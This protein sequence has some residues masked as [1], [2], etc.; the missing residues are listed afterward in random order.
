MYIFVNKL[1]CGCG[2][3]GT[4]HIMFKHQVSPAVAAASVGGGGLLLL[5]LLLL[6]FLFEVTSVMLPFW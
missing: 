6:L 1:L 4:R 5:L 2:D 3:C